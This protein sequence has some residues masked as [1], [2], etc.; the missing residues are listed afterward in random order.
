MQVWGFF[1]YRLPPAFSLLSSTSFAFPLSHFSTLPPLPS[2]R[3]DDQGR[4]GAASRLHDAACENWRESFVCVCVLVSVHVLQLFSFSLLFRSDLHF[5]AQRSASLCV[6]P[7]RVRYPLV[8]YIPKRARPKFDLSLCPSPSPLPLSCAFP[9][10]LAPRTYTTAR[11]STVLRSQAHQAISRNDDD[12]HRCV[13]VCVC[14]EGRKCKQRKVNNDGMSASL[15]VLRSRSDHVGDSALHHLRMC[16]WKGGSG[17]GEGV[18]MFVCVC[19][20]A[21]VYGRESACGSLSFSVLTRACA[22]VWVWVHTR[23]LIGAV[24]VPQQNTQRH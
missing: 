10:P 19:G 20:G 16:V 1:H 22:W 17:G 21:S 13:R 6:C 11:V 5:L 24:T 8:V 7:P 3:L 12:G 4:H 14:V 23:R 18:H 2:H 9:R 15:R